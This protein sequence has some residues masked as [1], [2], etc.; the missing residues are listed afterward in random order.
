MAVA[1]ELDQFGGGDPGTAA[2]AW[3]RIKSLTVYGYFTSERVMTEVTK[4]PIT[5][6]RFA[7]CIVVESQG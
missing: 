2:W 6:G 3:T 5:P 4:D 7:G 1:G